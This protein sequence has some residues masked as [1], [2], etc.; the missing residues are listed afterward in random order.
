MGCDGD[1][2]TSPQPLR[3]IGAEG[4]ATELSAVLR[5]AMRQLAEAG[6]EQ[7]RRE[8]RLLLAAALDCEPGDL[9]ARDDQTLD[10]P[11]QQRLQGFVE[12][13]LA[14]EPIARI[15]GHR[16]FWSLR[17]EITPDTLDPRPDSETLVEAVLAN[18]GDRQR[19][20]RVLDLG[21]GSGCLLLAL[22]S[23]LP[24]A[25]GLGIDCSS[26]AVA[27]ARRNAAALGF[28]DRARIEL[29]DWGRALEPG[30]DIILA[31]PPYINSSI[32]GD[33]MPEV[34]DYEPRLALDGGD[35]GLD[36]YRRLAPELAQLLAAQGI[37]ALELG[38]GQFPA[39]AE[40]IKGVGLA[41]LGARHDLSGIERCM[42]IGRV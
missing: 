33:L 22:L 11:T 31:N 32:I 7:P 38:E 41:I 27:T 36:A 1:S 23:E 19:P 25:S 8:A 2:P 26:G 16:E 37:A 34:R 35:D 18:L 4:R 12:R 21:V 40:L 17:F 13:R 6:I 5:V 10:E 39:V 24:R 15:R 3:P 9:I 42:M 14:R 20:Y 30:F 28:A 29:G